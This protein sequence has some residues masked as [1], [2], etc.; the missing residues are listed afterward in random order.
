MTVKPATTRDEI[1]ARLAK[2][3]ADLARF[4]LRSLAMFGSAARRE[5]G[6]KSDVD[7]LVTFDGPATFDGYMDLKTYLEELLGRRVDLVTNGALKPALRSKIA[8][9]LVDVA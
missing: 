3:R 1:L 9:E 7:M 4:R 8:R 2:H 5:L 6:A